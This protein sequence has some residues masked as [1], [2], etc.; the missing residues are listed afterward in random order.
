[1]NKRDGTDLRLRTPSMEQNERTG[2]TEQERNNFK[3]VITCPTLP[4]GH[5]YLSLSTFKETIKMF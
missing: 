2:G 3:K 1:M 4:V 5:R